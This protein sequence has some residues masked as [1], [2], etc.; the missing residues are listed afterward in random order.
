MNVHAIFYAAQPR[1]RPRK[2]IRSILRKAL[3][4]VFVVLCAAGPLRAQT[5]AISGTVT[6]SSG[7]VMSNVVVMLQDVRSQTS[8]QITTDGAGRY[9]F[10]RLASGSYELTFV[11]EGFET[12]KKTILL[13][14]E[15]AV[16]DVMLGV[17]G[18]ST[19]VSVKEAGGTVA[20]IAGKTTASRLDIPDTDLPAQ[21]SS[22]PQQVLESQG[23]NDMVSAF[24]NVSGVSA[25]V[26]YGMYEWSINAENLFN[27]RRYF[28]ASDYDNQ[29]YPGPPINL[30]T[31]IR[32][33][34]R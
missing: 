16:L 19:T 11:R 25:T 18:V 22:I 7:G 20:D 33:R 15:S 3:A 1:M 26:R 6:D 31:T 28:T 10:E 23:V 12:A 2:S 21:V 30:F 24:R 8:Q 17:S 34:F 5:A 4:C 27:R 9:R 13:A 32:L 29:I 14:T